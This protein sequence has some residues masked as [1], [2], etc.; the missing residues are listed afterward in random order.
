M[1]KEKEK[2][3]IQNEITVTTFCLDNVKNFP[4]PKL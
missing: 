4:L 2:K 1:E 3:K